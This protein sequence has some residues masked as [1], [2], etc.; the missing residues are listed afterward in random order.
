MTAL[1]IWA[2]IAIAPMLLIAQDAA[3]PVYP[4]Y[5]LQESTL[6]HLD[7]ATGDRTL[8]ANFASLS[9]IAATQPD[10]VDRRLWAADVDPSGR[11]LYQIEA[12]GHSTNPRIPG[13]P[14]GAALV[15][16]N[17]T[18]FERE[19]VFNRAN[20][21]NFVLSPN[22][23]R[24]LVF[25]YAG[26]YL[27]STQMVCVWHV[28]TGNCM[29]L[30]YDYVARTGFW[31]DE[32]TFV[33]G[34]N[35][36][37]P[38]RLIEADTKVQSIITL[39][40]EWYIYWAA[41]IPTSNS[42]LIYVH[43]REILLEI[44]P[45]SFILYDI[46]TGNTHLLPYSALDTSDYLTIDEILISPDTQYMLYKGLRTALV[47]FTSGALIQEFTAAYSADWIDD[48]TL[49]IQGSRNDGP[50]EIMRVDASTSQVQTLLSGEDAEGLLLF[51]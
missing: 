20:V 25:F 6:S 23:Q 7:L 44:P 11:Y 46:P 12:W 8:V 15:R 22:G 34:T 1:A 18:T 36:S 31:V 43:P 40:H 28:I 26:E 42:L 16:V 24:M 45:I 9:S 38:L 49:L 19:P 4:A 14:T 51:P 27:H 50:L 10:R 35:D 21:F 17:L 33:I 48:H 37:D 30:D 13:A 41:P 47:D 5:L 3:P 39:P 32:D 2:L 29:T